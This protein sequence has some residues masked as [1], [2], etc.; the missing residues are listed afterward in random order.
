MGFP[1]K[2]RANPFRLYILKTKEKIKVYIEKE[3]NL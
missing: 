3:N 1:C 2:G